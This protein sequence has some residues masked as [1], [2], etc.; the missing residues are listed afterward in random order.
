MNFTSIA[1][2]LSAFGLSASAGLNAYIPLLIVALV[3]RF[4]PSVVRL[5]A[6]WD[7]MT[8]WWVIG[9]LAVLTLIEILADKIPLV[10]HANDVL[11]TVVRPAAGA[12]LFASTTGTVSYLDPNVALILGLFVAGATHGAK[13]TAR[14]VVTATTGGLGN[15]IVSTIEDIASLFTSLV[16]IFMPIVIGLGAVVFLLILVVWRMGR[17]PG[18]VAGRA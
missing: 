14:P 18:A 7:G 2:L 5:S 10:D 15:P 11:G 8:S 3:G 1:T 13:A 12:V 9:T 4:A 6:P 16:A 17:R